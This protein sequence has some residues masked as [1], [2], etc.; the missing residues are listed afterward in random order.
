MGIYQF[1]K[2]KMIRPGV[3][4]DI[5]NRLGKRKSKTYF[6]LAKTPKAFDM[7]ILAILLL[8][9]YLAFHVGHIQCSWMFTSVF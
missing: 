8:E 9:S 2:I 6:N 4:V 5:G 7:C 1:V 3:G